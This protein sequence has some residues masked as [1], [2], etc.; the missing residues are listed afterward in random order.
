[1]KHFYLIFFILIIPISNHAQDTGEKRLGSWVDIISTNKITDRISINGSYTSWSYELTD[2]QHL[3]LGLIGVY[4]KFKKNASAGLLIGRASIDSNYES[5]NPMTIENRIAE[6]LSINHGHNKVKW[7]HRFRLEHRFFNYSDKED[8]LK[9]RLRYRFK[10]KLPL[11]KTFYASVYNEIHF[12]LNEFDFNQNRIYG[13]IGTKLNQNLSFDIGYVR[14]SF[15]TKSF[16]RLTFQLNI[17]LDFRK[18]K[19]T[20]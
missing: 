1:M 15:K 2:N 19:P 18:Q 12:N 14:H 11:N 6:Q 7:S 8:V 13:G 17:N 20:S 5:G 4:Y 9:H 16:N 10:G 3:S